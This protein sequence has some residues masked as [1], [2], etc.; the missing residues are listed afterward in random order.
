M[1]GRRL[2]SR[3]EEWSAEFWL[4]TRPI[5]P[6]SVSDPHGCFCPSALLGPGSPTQARSLA[7]REGR[8]SHPG[9]LCVCELVGC[10]RRTLQS[11]KSFP[12]PGALFPPERVTAELAGRVF[13]V[14]PIATWLILPVVICLSQ[15]LSHACL[16]TY[17][18]IVKPRMAH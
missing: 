2:G 4:F 5:P 3:G 13:H 12:G 16:S 17:F 11:L 7:G 18:Y 10:R 14:S 9:Y 1:P 15:R 6:R 8:S